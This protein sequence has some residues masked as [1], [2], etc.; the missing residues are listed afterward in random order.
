MQVSGTKSLQTPVTAYFLTGGTSSH[1][2]RGCRTDL[3]QRAF[4]FVNTS[5]DRT[6]GSKVI[7]WMKGTMLLDLLGNGGRI[8]TERLGNVLHGHVL[9]KTFFNKYPVIKS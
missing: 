7:V 9:V 5:V 8:L 1:A 3:F 2:E 4:L 6:F